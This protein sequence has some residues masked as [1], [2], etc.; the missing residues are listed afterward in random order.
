MTPLGAAASDLHEV[1]ALVRRAGTSFYRGMKVLPPDRRAAMYAIYAFCRLVDDVAD[2]PG[3]LPD[4]LAGLAAWRG[5]IAAVYA[6][7]ANDAVTRV[8][9]ETSDGETTWETIG[10]AANILEASWDALVESVTYGLLRSG[11]PVR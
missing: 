6:G 4:K 1:E 5:R 8:L 3:P 10:V 9:I 11:V 2:E 7:Q